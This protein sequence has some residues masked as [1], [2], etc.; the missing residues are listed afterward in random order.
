VAIPATR[1]AVERRG[2]IESFRPGAR[3]I[4]T[5]APV[6]FDNK[7]AYRIKPYGV[8]NSDIA[9]DPPLFITDSNG[10]FLTRNRV[11]RSARGALPV[12]LAPRVATPNGRVGVV[13]NHRPGTQVRLVSGRR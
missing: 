13:R 2:D 11:S 10:N 8:A 12:T 6:N 4:A 3:S 5:L 9:A 1:K 7:P